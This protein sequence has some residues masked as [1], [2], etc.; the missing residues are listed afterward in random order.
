MIAAVIRTTPPSPRSMPRRHL[1]L[2]ACLLLP[3]AAGCQM[4]SGGAPRADAA[5]IVEAAG[6]ERAV[7]R[8]SA[9]YY[10]RLLMPPGS[11]LSVRLVDRD[12]PAD[13]AEAILAEAAFE[14]LPGPPY[15]FVLPYD[16]E[17]LRA[18]GRYGLH[19]SLTTP[20]GET[21]F[22]T[23]EP[24]PWTPETDAPLEFRMLRT[25]PS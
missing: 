11:V 19:A 6:P 1:L 8:A 3:L 4:P 25:S 16:P 22:A 10:E 2:L 12:A 24:A 21:F 5:A 18:D 17:R 15:A 14:G 23:R 7:I 9:T 20:Q 13:S